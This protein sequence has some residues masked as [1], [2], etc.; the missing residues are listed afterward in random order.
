MVFRGIT[1]QGVTRIRTRRQN[2]RILVKAVFIAVGVAVCVYLGGAAASLVTGSGWHLPQLHLRSPLTGNGS[3]INLSGKKGNTKHFQFPATLAMPASWRATLIG[4]LPLLAGWILLLRSPLLRSRRH[5]GPDRHRGFAAVKDIRELYSARAARA[6]GV[7]TLPG[8]TR[9]QR[10]VLPLNSFGY[11][12]G[13]PLEPRVKRMRLWFNFETRLRIVARA[14]WGKS[15][16]LLIPIIRSLPGAAV[17]TSVEPEIF[18]TTVKARMWRKPPV[19]F[20]WMR[21]L[22]KKW[23]TEVRYPVYVADLSAPESKFAS[24]FPAVRWNPIVGCENFKV[25]TNRARALVSGGDGDGKSDSGTDKFFRDSASEVLAAWLQAAA[26]NPGKDI[27]DLVRWLRDT[28]LATAQD[29]LQTAS[30]PEATTAIMNM[31][32]HLDPAAGRTTSGVKRYLNFAISSLASG[33]G[34]ALCGPRSGVQFD[35][36][37]L[38]ADGGTVYL[39]AEPE[40]MDQARPILTLFATEMFRAAE[41]VARQL[42]GSRL[43]QTF[44]GVFDEL[45]AGVRLPLLPYV[46]AVQRKY[47][48]SY[49]YA[50]QSSSDEDELFGQAGAERLRNQSTTIIGGYD[51]G[52]AQETTRRA[53]HHGVVG[54]SKAVNGFGGSEQVQQEEV[55]PES[56]QQKIK[57]GQSI[58]LGLGIAPFLAYTD[59][60]DAKRAVRK[61]IRQQRGEVEQFIV[62]HRR[63][64]LAKQATNAGHHAAV[65]TAA[66]TGAAAAAVIGEQRIN[67]MEEKV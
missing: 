8:T 59:R 22:R 31:V 60:I 48:I 45:F 29:I 53:G 66:G 4:A 36:A 46:A 11:H 25:A 61:D 23:R 44:M 49:C 50:I 65:T 37:K 5:T 26:L 17:V 24:G 19:R 14:G 64:E 41:R 58:I 28:D 47:G 32:T 13:S 6:A 52:S 43:P 1:E 16:R 40:E 3:L 55:L 39:L 2:F 54:R 18:T 15:W 42:P 35:L 20:A 9:W 62:R 34:R 51:V 21:L 67:L 12:V 33:Q 63:A 38:I 27:E 10:M 57:N 56:D 30:T 7:F